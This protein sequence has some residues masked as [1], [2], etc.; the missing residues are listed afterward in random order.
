MITE[1]CLYM[2]ESCFI[3]SIIRVYLFYPIVCVPK[4]TTLQ[5]SYKY[6]FPLD[7]DLALHLPLFVDDLL[8]RPLEIPRIN[9]EST[10]H[11]KD[12]LPQRKI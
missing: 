4:Y 3:T 7:P 6:P 11:P 12:S 5:S 9:H 1:P 8:D 10:H 2:W